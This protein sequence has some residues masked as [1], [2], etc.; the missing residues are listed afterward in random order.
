MNDLQSRRGA[1]A[2]GFGVHLKTSTGDEVFL[3]D[4]GISRDQEDGSQ[5]YARLP[6]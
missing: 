2:G 5:A 3:A 1:R 4:L 6:L